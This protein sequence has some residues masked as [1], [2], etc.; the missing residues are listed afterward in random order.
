MNSIIYITGLSQAYHTKIRFDFGKKVETE[1]RSKNGW[2][3]H[4]L[5]ISCVLRYV[6]CVFFLSFRVK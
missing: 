4:L 3:M 1:L 5:S 2:R 6:F